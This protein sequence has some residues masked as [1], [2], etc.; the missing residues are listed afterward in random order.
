MLQK[1]LWFDDFLI[2]YRVIITFIYFNIDASD[3]SVTIKFLEEGLI[4][5][6]FRH[7]N[8]LGLIGLTFDPQG[9]PLVILPLMKNGDLKSFMK[10]APMV[11]TCNNQSVG[12]KLY[13]LS[14]VH[15]YNLSVVHLK[16]NTTVIFNKNMLESMSI[17]IF[18][19]YCFCC[20]IL[21]IIKIN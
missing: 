17:Q 13:N 12:F 8:V 16:G 21:L 5:K 11:S 6:D 19:T 20:T 7:D 2:V 3:P 14:I 9:N 18:P 4:M 10:K 1:R 15:L